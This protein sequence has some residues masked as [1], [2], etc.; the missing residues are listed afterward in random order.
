MP[1]LLL[2]NSIDVL[3]V[4]YGG[5]GTT[6]IID[7]LSG[8]IRTNSKGDE[9]GYKHLPLP[10]ISFRK[11]VRFVYIF[12]DPVEAA[13]SL[14]R[15][16]YQRR[17]SKMLQ[18][19][20]GDFSP[21]PTSMSIDEYL[22]QGVDLLRFQT[23]FLNWHDRYL[24]CVPT[25]FLKYETLFEDAAILGEF[26]GLPQ[27]ALNDY[28]KRRPREAESREISRSLIARADEIYGE[29]G[30]YLSELPDH[31]VRRRSTPAMISSLFGAPYARA[32]FVEPARSPLKSTK[33]LLRR[34]LRKSPG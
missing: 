24:S 1:H 18:R 34:V 19:W 32:A 30:R 6:T 11:D 22:D 16:G 31:E 29:F 28:P 10:P 14:F 9:D 20:S 26:L 15:R 23:H 25:L 4:S 3:V 8:Y 7:F 5:V 12:G 27:E 21:I 2:P 17:Q 13:V 33:T